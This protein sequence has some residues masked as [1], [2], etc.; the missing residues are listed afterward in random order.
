MPS[1]G[2]HSL[3]KK[4]TVYPAANPEKRRESIKVVSS[5][6]KDKPVYVDASGIDVH[7]HR[8]YARAP[9][10]TTVVSIISGRQLARESFLVAKCGTDSLAPLFCKSI[11]TAELFN[12]CLEEC[13]L[14][15]PRPGRGDGQCQHPTAG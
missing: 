3:E 11:A 6:S 8:P 15:E 13:L 1:P 10:G 5:S 7:P 9:R 14:P 12:R 4:T 2:S